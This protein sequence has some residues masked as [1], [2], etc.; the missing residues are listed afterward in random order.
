MLI[1]LCCARARSKVGG[2]H[3]TCVAGT[4]YTQWGF[5]AA[6]PVAHCFLLPILGLRGPLSSFQ[7]ITE[8]LGGRVV[9]VGRADADAPRHYR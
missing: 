7:A 6:W 8:C 3:V 9:G 1:S 4:M 5:Y 2:L